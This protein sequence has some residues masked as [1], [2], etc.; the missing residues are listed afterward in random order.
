M[1]AFTHP[2]VWLLETLRLWQ[3]DA[4]QESI[5]EPMDEEDPSGIYDPRNTSFWYLPPPC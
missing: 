3:H 4:T 2:I 1:A 5:E